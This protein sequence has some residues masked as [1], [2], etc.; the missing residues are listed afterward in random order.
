M[1]NILLEVKDKLAHGPRHI[2]AERTRSRQAAG[3][4]LAFY[5]ERHGGK[6][7]PFRW[8][9]VCGKEGVM[10]VD[11]SLFDDLESCT[12]CLTICSMGNESA[13]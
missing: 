11:C 7:I 10:Y 12:E 1:T 3:K 6:E 8:G 13:R 5:R 9:S 2:P 4:T